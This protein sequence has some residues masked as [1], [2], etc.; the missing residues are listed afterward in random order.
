MM[1]IKYNNLMTLEALDLPK[2]YDLNSFGREIGLSNTILYL[3]SKQTDKFYKQIKISKKKSGTRNISIPSISMKIVQK[4][5][6]VNILEKIPISNCAMAFRKGSKYGIKTNAELHKYNEYIIRID[7]KDFFDSIKSEMVFYLFRSIGY[8]NMI[9]NILTNICTYKECLP[10]GAVTSPILSNLV[11]KKLD[12][13]LQGLSSKRDIVYTRYADDLIFS[14]ND[15]VLLIKTIKIVFD[16]IEDEGFEINQ[17]KTKFMSINSAKR[18]TGLHIEKNKVVVPKELKRKV[19]SMIHYS[20]STGDYSKIDQIKGYIS[21]I[22]SIE[23]GY[24]A[25]IATYINRI[26]NDDRYKVFNDIVNSY[27]TNK[28][29]EECDDMIFI[30]KYTEI[31]DGREYDLTSYYY[32]KRVEYLA[33]KE[34][35]DVIRNLG[36]D[37]TYI[38][39]E[40]INDEDVPF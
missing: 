3:L 28:I 9:S 29:L 30:N 34:L 20:I 32:E 25:K 16:I 11:C 4:W 15:E 12:R 19:R 17:A 35:Y 33:K 37:E 31:I 10:Q 1:N 8:N 26:A 24:R 23:S 36:F 39:P 6:Q 7:L 40:D 38:S 2:I 5:I 22:S 21:F 13:R 18:I 27:N 14:C